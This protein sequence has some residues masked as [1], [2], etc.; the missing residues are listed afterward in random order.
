MDTLEKELDL[1]KRALEA[2][3]ADEKKKAHN[4]RSLD[5]ELKPALA[6]VSRG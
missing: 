4:C 3:K 6:A 2:K 1:I 5:L